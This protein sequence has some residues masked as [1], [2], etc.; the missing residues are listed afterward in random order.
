MGC[1]KTK[2]QKPEAHRLR[3]NGENMAYCVNGAVGYEHLEDAD[4]HGRVMGPG[5]QV[6]DSDIQAHPYETRLKENQNRR[7]S[8]R[9]LRTEWDVR[10][11][12]IIVS[13]DEFPGKHPHEENN[14][15][16][17]VARRGN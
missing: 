11:R 15:M 7:G 4:W 9:Q 8:E 3:H 1:L 13:R 2:C 10:Q 16:L 6:I 5:V 14:E 17:D 12:D